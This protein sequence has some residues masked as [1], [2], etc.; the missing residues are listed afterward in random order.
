MLKKINILF[1]VLFLI[2]SIIFV[3]E[4]F[5]ITTFFYTTN[6]KIE[7]LIYIFLSIFSTS[8]I[9][10]NSLKKE[11]K[12]VE[13]IIYKEKHE[14]II[15]NEQML[16]KSEEILKNKARELATDLLEN[17]KIEPEINK[18]CD[19]LLINFAKKFNFVQG[20]FFVL[21]KR[22]SKFKTTGTYAFYSEEVYREFEL[23]EGLT[24][25]VAKEK[26]MLIINNIPEKY[27]TILSGLGNGTPNYLI[28]LPIVKEDSTIALLEFASFEKIDEDLGKIFNYLATEIANQ[29]KI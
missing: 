13:K 3:L 22:D 24:G 1:F 10:I 28:I 29:I 20:V 19:K 2:I 23:G 12:I 25:Q 27:I 14:E 18:Y 16:I 21:D 15:D 17:L 4:I 9:F 5:E 6:N 8:F 26:K 11:T 7:T